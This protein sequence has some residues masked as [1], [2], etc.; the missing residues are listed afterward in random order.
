M[1]GLYAV[2]G[3]AIG[4]SYVVDSKKTV[5]GLKKGWKKFSK[6]LPEYLKL[7]IL[8]SIVLLISE[9]YIIKYLGQENIF[10]GLM[11]SLLLGSITMMPGF[12]AY[13]L[14]KILIAKGVSYMV[15]AGFVT[16]L[17]L[18]GV[19]T[20]PLEKKYFGKKATVLRN[21]MSFGVAA[22][23]ALLMGIFYREVHLL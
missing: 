19:V 21:I 22:G 5:E 10:L 23:I 8:I 1:I 2:A 9:D 6:S 4:I 20:Y 3:L 13:P 12:I 18:V 7:L 15:V 11:S 17:M 16:S 14:A